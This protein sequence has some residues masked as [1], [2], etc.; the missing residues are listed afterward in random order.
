MKFDSARRR[1]AYGRGFARFAATPR[2][3][4]PARCGRRAIPDRE[5]E[6][7]S[8]LAAAKK[9]GE[10]PGILLPDKGRRKTARVKG[11]CHRNGW[12]AKACGCPAPIGDDNR[13]EDSAPAAL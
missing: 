3:R 9:R 7:C 5:R 4:Q 6:R 2:S 1:S 8:G 11:R 12:P 10:S 13:E